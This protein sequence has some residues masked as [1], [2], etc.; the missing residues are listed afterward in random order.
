LRVVETATNAGGD[1]TAASATTGVVPIPITTSPPPETKPPVVTRTMTKAL[2]RKA[3]RASLSFP[4]TTPVAGKLLVRWY[5]LKTKKT[6]KGIL[7]ASGHRTFTK[8]GTGRIKMKLTKK[9]K[10]ILRKGK[11]VKVLAKAKF[12]P[13]RGKALTVSRKLTVKR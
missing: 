2:L 6:K 3:L 7:L 9:G 4:F 1:G 13:L 10:R 12:T 8:P 11:K 5:S